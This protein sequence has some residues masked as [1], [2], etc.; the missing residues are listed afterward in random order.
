LARNKTV[1]EGPDPANVFT[2]QNVDPLAAELRV[3]DE[4]RV[5]ELTYQ[6]NSVG[7][8]YHCMRDV[9]QNTSH[10]TAR[11]KI[12]QLE[13]AAEELLRKIDALDHQSMT[14][15]RSSFRRRRGRDPRKW[16]APETARRVVEELLHA[17]R[18]A[19]EES[20]KRGRP[21]NNPLHQACQGLASL[22]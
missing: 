7:C 16:L 14:W 21:N 17:A 19:L 9:Q 4:E 22:Y 18:H 5:R 12:G 1:P 11:K 13:K 2:R 10:P 3:S 20:P 15:L 6:L 8:W